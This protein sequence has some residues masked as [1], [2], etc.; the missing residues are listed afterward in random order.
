MSSK[1][2]RLEDLLKIRDQIK[3]EGKKIVFTNGCFD[4]IHKGHIHLLQKAREYGDFLVVG[5]ND[6]SSVE[7]LKGYPRPIFSLKERLEILEALEPVD[8]LIPFSEDTPQRL[9]SLLLP[10]FLVKGGDWQPEE[11]VGRED[12]E[13]A[14][15]EVIVIPYLESYSTTEIIT[16][17]CMIGKK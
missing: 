14:G 6:D 3:R 1:T 7:K 9:I 17:I 11:I 10:D 13:G 15:G 4:L 16:R 12:V 5:I 8:F 2:Q